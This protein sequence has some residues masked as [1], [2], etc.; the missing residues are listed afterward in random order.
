MSQDKEKGFGLPRV[1]NCGKVNRWGT[2]VGEKGYLSKFVCAGSSQCQLF[3][4][5]MAI[6]FPCERAF[7]AALISQEFLLA[8]RERKL[9][10][11]IFL[12]L[13]TLKCLQLK[14]ILKP[15]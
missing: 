13:L 15:K 12:H 8:V 10:K 5:F 4:S 9:Q 3:F 7:I 2:L 11:A 1:V 6:K 14:I